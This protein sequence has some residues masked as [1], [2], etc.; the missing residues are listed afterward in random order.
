MMIKCIRWPARSSYTS[1]KG[2]SKKQ[3]STKK[4]KQTKNLVG[5]TFCLLDRLTSFPRNAFYGPFPRWM[6]D[7]QRI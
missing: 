2:G 4:K 5:Q 1:L 3:I 7:I 6:C